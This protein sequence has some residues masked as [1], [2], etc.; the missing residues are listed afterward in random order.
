LVGV[1]VASIG[2]DGSCHLSESFD[3][4]DAL[5]P[6]LEAWASDWFT[7]WRGK[8]PERPASEFISA[9]CSDAVAGV[10]DALIVLAEKANG[11]AELLSWVG[12]GPL[13]DLVSHYGHATAV[14]DDVERAA[15]QSTSVRAAL[16]NVWL[17]NEVPP[18]ARSRLVKLGATSLTP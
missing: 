12:A 14:V 8:G 10:V 11:D 16:Q 15:R 2:A 7:E 5:W 17:G 1:V 3:G 4:N 6:T 9:A 13:E 18:D